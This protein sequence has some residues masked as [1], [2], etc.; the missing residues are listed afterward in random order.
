MVLAGQMAAGVRWIEE[1]IRRF[2]A[3]GNETAPAFGHL[4][5]GEMYLQ[6]ILREQPVPT[7]ILLRNLGFA[8]RTLPVAGRK[9]RRHLEEAIRMARAAAIPAVLARSLLDL[10]RLCQTKRRW[11]EA[12][13]HLD[14]ARQIAETLESPRLTA[15][16]RAAIESLNRVTA[17]VAR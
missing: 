12:R 5:L 15:R 11:R 6:M 3:W 2:S 17:G 8:L 7:D 13:T 16:I 9:A 14:E 1:A 10:G 4:I